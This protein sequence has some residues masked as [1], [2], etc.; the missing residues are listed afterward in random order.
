MTN[1]FAPDFAAELTEYFASG[2][3]ITAPPAT[4]YVTLYDG[5]GNELNADLQNGRVGVTVGSG[6]TRTNTAF[7]N[8]NEINFGEAL[9]DITVQEFA[10]KDSDADD[11]TA[12]EYFRADIVDA[13]QDFA[14]ETRVFFAAGDLD[15]D[16]LD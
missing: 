15:V 16:I 2:T 11:A 8:T 1:D 12:L 10:I 6:W 4:V 7:E 5:A 13:P 9:S 14:A 3:D